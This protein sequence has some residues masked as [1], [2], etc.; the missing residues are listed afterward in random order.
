VVD[1]IEYF[2]WQ[3]ILPGW[4]TWIIWIP[5]PDAALKFDIWA[6][7]EHVQWSAG[8]FSKTVALGWTKAAEAKGMNLLQMRH[9]R[10]EHRD[11]KE[12]L[13]A[14]YRGLAML[15][16]TRYVTLAGEQVWP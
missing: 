3:L 7:D 16:L 1:P 15:S 4:G 9:G 10:M 6:D 2:A 5:E 14:A 12:A 8:G 11:L 13:D